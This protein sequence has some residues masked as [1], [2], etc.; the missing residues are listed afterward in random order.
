MIMATHLAQLYDLD[1][2]LAVPLDAGCRRE[3]LEAQHD[4]RAA[5]RADARHHGGVEVERA[6]LARDAHALAA[7]EERVMHVARD[8]GGDRDAL[9][10]ERVEREPQV[11]ISPVALG[12]AEVAA[13]GRIARR[14]EPRR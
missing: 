5:A 1:A 4:D 7:S 2:V 10:A 12:R 13:V 6:V 9:D 3:P 8:D 11:G 14:A